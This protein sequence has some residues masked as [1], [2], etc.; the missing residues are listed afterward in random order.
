MNPRMMMTK[1][2]VPKS[3]YHALSILYHTLCLGGLLWQLIEI[4]MNYFKYGIISDIKVIMPEKDI[5][6]KYFNFCY[7]VGWTHEYDSNISRYGKPGDELFEYIRYNLTLREQFSFEVPGNVIPSRMNSIPYI[8]GN[9]ICHQLHSKEL[10]QKYEIYTHPLR[11]NS[12]IFL[13]VTEQLPWVDLWRIIAFS[14]ESENHSVSIGIGDYSFYLHKLMAPYSDDCMNFNNLGFPNRWDA[15]RSCTFKDGNEIKL[16]RKRIITTNDEKYL[17][18]RVSRSNE[19]SNECKIYDRFEC[20]QH[21][22]FTQIISSGK[23]R[24]IGDT[25]YHIMLRISSHPSF[26]IQSKPKIEDV[27]FVTFIFGALGTWVGFSFLFIN[28]IPYFVKMR[29]APMDST[30]ENG[31]NHSVKTRNGKLLS[32]K[33]INFIFH[34]IK[35]DSIDIDRLKLSNVRMRERIRNLETKNY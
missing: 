9:S 22:I 5:Y 30:D 3:T 14:H 34:K 33:D 21:A 13:Q 11:N 24:K 25:I 7:T 12:Y 20:Y 29:D 8:R 2:I 26:R 18:Y 31:A 19:I 35:S 4:S 32:K 16:D 1:R 6:D 17:D 15:M 10:D 28:P 27:D 23:H